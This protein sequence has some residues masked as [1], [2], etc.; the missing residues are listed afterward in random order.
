MIKN[1]DFIYI[2]FFV[3]YFLI[4]LLINIEENEFKNHFFLFFILKNMFVCDI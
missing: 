4:L 2:L 1:N 3:N